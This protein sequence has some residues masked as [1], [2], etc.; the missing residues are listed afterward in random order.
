MIRK[1]HLP[2]LT[3]RI[4]SGQEVVPHGVLVFSLEERRA[5]KHSRTE[6]QGLPT[7]CWELHSTAS[8]IGSLIPVL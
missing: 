6:H 4:F 2:E 5:W 8:F 1:H 3:G 7:S